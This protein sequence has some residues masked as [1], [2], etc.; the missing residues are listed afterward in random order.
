MAKILSEGTLKNRFAIGKSNEIGL[1]NSTGVLLV[2]DSSS[3][4]VYARVKKVNDNATPN[5][6]DVTTYFDL[7]GK[8]ANITFDFDGASAPSAGTNTG[9]FGFCH[10]SGSTFNAGEIYYDNGSA[11]IEVLHCTHITTSTAI[12]GTVSLLANGS[13]ALQSGTWTLKGDGSGSGE[14]TGTV[15]T[16]KIPFT[17]DSTTV[18]STTSLLTN[19]E[20]ISV[21]V[22]KSV[23]F[24]GTAPTLL[25]ARGVTLLATADNDLKSTIADLSLEPIKI[26]ADGVVA[27]TVTADGSSAGSG[28]VIITYSTTQNV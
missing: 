10:T 13:Y 11:L 26:L 23:A 17:K 3:A 15:K 14:P 5:A 8:I 1:E 20:I 24:N 18:N 7:A 28:D 19:T 4:L 9:E 6:N 2:E 22:R 12:T 27:L 21:A 16:L 25:V